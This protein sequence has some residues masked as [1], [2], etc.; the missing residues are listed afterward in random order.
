MESIWFPHPATGQ[1]KRQKLLNRALCLQ[2]TW[3]QVWCSLAQHCA[4]LSSIADARGIKAALHSPD[5]PSSP[6]KTLSSPRA[7]AG[8]C[9]LSQ[10]APPASLW[11]KQYCTVS[12]VGP[13]RLWQNP[14]GPRCHFPLCT[15]RCVLA[16]LP[17]I[18]LGLGTGF[19]LN[20]VWFVWVF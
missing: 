5:T 11:A 14:S 10:P 3:R 7:P 4:F 20:E 8:A 9:E 1:P 19:V 2:E 6:S 15:K 12:T 18:A 17:F 13:A 16:S